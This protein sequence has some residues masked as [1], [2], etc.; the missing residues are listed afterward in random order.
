MN[1]PA[2]AIVVGP[3][4]GHTVQ[5][6][7]GGPLTFKARGGETGG[8][9]LAME[10]VV[11]PGEGPPL[12]THAEQDEA[13]YVLEGQLRFTLGE[14]VSDAPA[15]SFV[16]VPRGV[17]HNFRNTGDSP[18]RLLVLFTPAGM[19]AFFDRFATVPADSVSPATFAELGAD[20]GMAVTGPPLGSN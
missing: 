5:G 8:R 19:E 12:H 18:A 13:W 2:Q 14:Q 17:E 7:V 9:L 16:Y 10:N 11:A 15:G 20:V 3:G 1:T 6:P 4:E